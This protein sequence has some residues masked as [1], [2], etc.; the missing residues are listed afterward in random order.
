MT[1]V[2][3]TSFQPTVAQKLR[4]W[5][6]VELVQV[7]QETQAGISGIISSIYLTY[8]SDPILVT[9]DAD[10]IVEQAKNSQVTK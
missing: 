10:W 7:V 8:V 9:E 2:Q 4:V 5:V 3:M 6:D 1:L